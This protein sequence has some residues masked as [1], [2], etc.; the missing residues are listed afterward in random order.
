MSSGGRS[1]KRRAFGNPV[2]AED[3][4]ESR[5]KPLGN[6]GADVIRRGGEIGGREPL[7]LGRR[8]RRRARADRR[9]SI[10][11]SPSAPSAPAA[12]DRRQGPA[13]AAS[14]RPSPRRST[15]ASGARH[16]RYCRWRRGRRSRRSGATTPQS[17][18]AS[19]TG[20]WRVSMSARTSIAAARRPPS[21]IGQSARSPPRASTS[22]GA[23]SPNRRNRGRR[24]R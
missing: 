16:R 13:R 17:F 11:A 15:G 5:R 3:A 21:L 23:A 4:L 6:V 2:R 1:A 19:A 24:R 12:G 9:R 22:M 20:R 18:S 8:Q 10:A 7:R 14:P